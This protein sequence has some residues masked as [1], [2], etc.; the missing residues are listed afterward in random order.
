[1]KKLSVAAAVNIMV[2]LMLSISALAA[3]A[4]KLQ[5]VLSDVAQAED[6]ILFTVE[7]S[8]DSP[9]E[10]YA[11]L[12]FNLVSSDS[13]A[14]SIAPKES[15]GL[16]ITFADGYGSAY[17]NGRFNDGEVRYLLGIYG[18]TGRNVITDATDVCSVRMR[19]TGEAAPM[20]SVAD[21]KL[22]YKNPNGV[23]V[24]APVTA[25]IPAI[26]ISRESLLLAIGDEATPLSDGGL[27][28]IGVL[29]VSVLLLLLVIGAVALLSRRKRVRQ[30]S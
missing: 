20:L 4:A 28:G 22:V 30:G 25:E 26:E 18:R 7:I 13:S 27:S 3:P 6:D 24:S 2:F 8:I 11:S 19:Y 5:M 12:D 29:Q 21:F 23:I 1:M 10:P 15:G 17:H 16:D 9:S 14:L